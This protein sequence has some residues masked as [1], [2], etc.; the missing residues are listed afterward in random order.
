MNDNCV[1]WKSAGARSSTQRCPRQGA[2]ASK[3]E[4]VKKN[5]IFNLKKNR[6]N[7]PERNNCRVRNEGETDDKQVQ[8]FSNITTKA[9]L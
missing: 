4:N 3:D 2:P 9:I 5:Y 8:K 7:C 1:P 6:K